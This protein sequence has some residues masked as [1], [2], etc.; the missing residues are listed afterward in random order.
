M[1]KNKLLENQENCNL[2]VADLT[3]MDLN[4]SRIKNEQSGSE[5]PPNPQE[6]RIK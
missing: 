1:K 2:A 3:M 6:L 4:N 5:I